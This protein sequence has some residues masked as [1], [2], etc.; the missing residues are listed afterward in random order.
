MSASLA[1][2]RYLRR[3]LIALCAVMMLVILIVWWAVGPTLPKESTLGADELPHASPLPPKDAITI[4]TYNIG[5]GQGIK[6]DPTDWRDKKFTEK[7]MS[8]LAAVLAKIGSDIVLL[9]EVDLD[10]NRT[11][12]INEAQYL[13]ENAGYPYYACALLWD[14]NYIPFPIWPLAHHL[15]SMKAANCTLSRYP[16][17][18]HLRI[19]Y[20]KPAANPYWYNLGY[21]D[22]GAQRVEV[23]IGN[24]TLTVVNVHLEAYDI[25]T[26]EEQARLLMK[27]V[28]LI[29]GPYILGGDFN[30]LPPEAKVRNGFPDDPTDDESLDTTMQIVRNGFSHYNEALPLSLHQTDEQST[31]TFRSDKPTRRIDYIFGG[32]GTHVS[33]GRVVKEA[34]DA[35]DHLPVVATV[36]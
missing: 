5:H 9:Q 23:Q 4:T 15:G 19:V 36:Q 30:S 34:L 2:S 3:A 10:S 14:K 18:N 17:K 6:A 31:F 20:D 21:I 11:H 16:L 22:R 25:K 32:P 24:K 7:K 26:R 29:P 27:W 13:A 1:A 8:E 12:H 28:K 33:K 35:S